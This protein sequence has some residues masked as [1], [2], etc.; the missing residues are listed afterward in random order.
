MRGGRGSGTYVPTHSTHWQRGAAGAAQSWGRAMPKKRTARCGMT[1][2]GRR[3]RAWARALRRRRRTASG[4]APVPVL[5]HRPTGQGALGRQPRGGPRR[6]GA[7]SPTGAG[8]AQRARVRVVCVRGVGDQRAGGVGAAGEWASAQRACRQVVGYGREN[9]ME[10]AGNAGACPTKKKK[11][12]TMR[13]AGGMG[14]KSGGR[15]GGGQRDRGG[16]KPASTA[17]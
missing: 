14:R 3:W 6:A 11:R 2:T 16:V 13:G 9:V 5:H 12:S 10:T 8:R 7:P 17:P 4:G 15:G 1:P